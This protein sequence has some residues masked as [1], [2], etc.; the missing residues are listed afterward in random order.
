MTLEMRSSKRSNCWT[1]WR[2]SRRWVSTIGERVMCE[3]EYVVASILV[4]VL[5]GGLTAY[6][7]C[8][9][10][11]RITYGKWVFWPSED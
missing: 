1:L 6:V 3:P 5:I 10:E 11:T 4:S 8:V 7:L 2:R 9:I